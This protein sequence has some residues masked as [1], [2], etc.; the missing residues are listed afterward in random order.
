WLACV[1][2]A[3]SALPSGRAARTQWSLPSGASMPTSRRFA[4]RSAGHRAVCTS[5]RAVSRPAKSP[6]S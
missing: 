5:A 2:P 6:S 4:S 1:T 3:E